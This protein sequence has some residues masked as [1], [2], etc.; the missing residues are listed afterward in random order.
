MFG[1]N[2]N[3]RG[4][5]IAENEK[6]RPGR[7]ATGKDPVQALRMPPELQARISAWIERQPEPKPSRSE[8]IR[9]LIELGL[10]DA[11]GLS[12]KKS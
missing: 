1:Y 8:A 4:A 3:L 10:G 11:R 9:R 5:S 2:L 7:P 12:H 6:R